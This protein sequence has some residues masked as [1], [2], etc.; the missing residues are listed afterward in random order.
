MIG[1]VVWSLCAAVFLGI[2]LKVRKSKEAVA[3]F[4]FVKPPA[5]ND[6][7]RYNHSVSALWIVSSVILEIIGTPLWFYLLKKIE[8][9]RR[10]QFMGNEHK[11]LEFSDHLG[12]EVD[13]YAYGRL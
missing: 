2:G 7:D 13:L 12:C 9:W 4:T 1:F 11:D 8:I 6:V 10:R 3:F 5:V